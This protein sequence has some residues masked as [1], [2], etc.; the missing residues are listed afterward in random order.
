MRYLPFDL[1]QKHSTQDDI[2]CP[3]SQ[4]GFELLLFPRQLEFPLFQIVVINVSIRYL[5]FW[6]IIRYSMT[7]IYTS[8]DKVERCLLQMHSFLGSD[9]LFV[10]SSRVPSAIA[11]TRPMIIW[12]GFSGCPNR[13]WN[14]VLTVLSFTHEWKREELGVSQMHPTTSYPGHVD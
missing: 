4:R 2:Q 3:T 8:N 13:Y 1:G 10:R 5:F 9:S 11:F 7:M 6:P 12:S 14:E